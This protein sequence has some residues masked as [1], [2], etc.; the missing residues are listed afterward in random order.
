MTAGIDVNL[1]N[2]WLN[3]I[4]DA[5]DL[6]AAG[7]KLL[8]YGGTRPATGDPAL[9]INLIATLTFSPVC[10]GDAV[11]GVLTFNVIISDYA[12]T[13]LVGTWARITD[14]DDN[15]VMDLGVGKQI[16]ITGDIVS[17]SD[18]I[19]GLVSTSLIEPGMIVTAS[20]GIPDGTTVLSIGP[21]AGEVT[22]NQNATATATVTL[23]FSTPDTDLFFNDT[24]FTIGTNISVTSGHIYA[25]NE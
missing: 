10:A 14:S 15:F 13:D 17:G 19:T 4:R 9:P 2:G 21:G 1:R 24:N 22:L 12:G 16:I 23:D 3:D 25:G 7:G 11:L 20:S 18:V 6:G 5:I 8:I